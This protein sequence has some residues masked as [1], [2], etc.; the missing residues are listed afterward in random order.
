MVAQSRQMAMSHWRRRAEASEAAAAA[1]PIVRLE[2]AIIGRTERA[3]APRTDG[4]V[5]GGIHALRLHPDPPVLLR[6]RRPRFCRG[7]D[8]IGDQ[9]HGFKRLALCGWQ[10]EAGAWSRAS[11]SMDWHSLQCLADR[12]SP[13]RGRAQWPQSPGTRRPAHDHGHGVAFNALC[14]VGHS[15]CGLR[16]SGL[17]LGTVLSNN[18][19]RKQ[20]CGQ[21]CCA[22]HNRKWMPPPEQACRADGP[23]LCA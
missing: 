1:R 20:P 3:I 17:G 14:R 9:L 23:P 10:A 7:L 11:S 2:G 6:Q 12:R 4:D 13:H 19:H 18:R 15:C 5:A 21:R 8:R 22:Q 16:G